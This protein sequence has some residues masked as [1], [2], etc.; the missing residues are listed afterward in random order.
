MD[1]FFAQRKHLLL[2]ARSSKARERAMGPPAGKVRPAIT[3]QDRNPKVSLDASFPFLSFPFSFPDA[4]RSPCT[5]IP[6][7]L[8]PRDGKIRYADRTDPRKLLRAQP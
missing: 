4:S 7:N 5:Q 6:T 3:K 2:I 1:P 8:F